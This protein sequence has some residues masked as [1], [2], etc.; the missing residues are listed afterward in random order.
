MHFNENQTRLWVNMINLVE[1]FRFGKIR[2]SD[3]VYGLEGALDAGEFEDEYL[4]KQWYKFWLPLE[5]MSATPSDR[6]EL[7]DVSESLS[8]M[9]LFLRNVITSSTLPLPE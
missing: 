9:D 6:T 4:I 2:Y 1:D 7:K 3:M 5:I 8:E